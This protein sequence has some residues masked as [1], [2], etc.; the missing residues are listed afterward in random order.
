MDY[1]IFGLYGFIIL[2]II[3]LYYIYENLKENSL[4][5]FGSVLITIGYF[6]AITETYKQSNNNIS[7]SHLILCIFGLLSFIIPIN[8]HVKKNDIFGVIGHF[9]L[10]NSNF[11]YQEIANICLTIYY[12]LYAHRNI[13][14]SDIIENIKGIGGSLV[15]LYYIKE[16]IDIWYLQKEKSL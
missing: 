11:G 16:S 15:L 13:N 5:I 14:N 8:I 9:I 7:I 1:S 4:I 12:S 3:Y 10:I 2:F 6:Y